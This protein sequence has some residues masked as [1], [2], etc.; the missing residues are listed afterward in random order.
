MTCNLNNVMCDVWTFEV[1][2]DVYDGNFSP[3]LNRKYSEIYTYIFTL[4][5]YFPFFPGILFV[6]CPASQPPFQN[7]AS[8]FGWMT[9]LD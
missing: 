4:F 8:F 2:Y 5:M 9:N 3:F 7:G 6:H 1:W